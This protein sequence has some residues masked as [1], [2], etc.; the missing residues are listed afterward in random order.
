M[1]HHMT[2]FPGALLKYSDTADSLMRAINFPH[3]SKAPKYASTSYA[4]RRDLTIDFDLFLNFVS[5]PDISLE[6]KAEA[7]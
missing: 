7:K 4:N 2:D 1:H 3:V 6:T 5:F